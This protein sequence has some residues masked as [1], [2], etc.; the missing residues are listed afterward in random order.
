MDQEHVNFVQQYGRPPLPPQPPKKRRGVF[1]FLALTAIL[2]LGGFFGVKALISLSPSE[3]PYEYDPVTLEPKEPEGL[4]K[5]I[6]HFV[7]SKDIVLEGEKEDRI[8]ILLLGMGGPGHDGPYL[9]D[10]IIIASVKPSTG[11]VAMISI[12]RDLGVDIP[13]SG[14]RKINSANAIGENKRK[15]WGAAFATEL[16]EETFDIDIHYYVRVDFQAFEDIVNEVGGVSVNVD[17]SFTDYEYPA[18]YD[19]YQ[20]VSFQQ[21]IRKMNGETALTYARSRHGNNGEGSDFARAKRQQKVLLA[22]KEKILSARTLANPVKI[23]NIIESLD[24]HVTTNMEF[25]DIIEFLKTGRSVNSNKI[26]TVVLDNSPDGYL[27]NAYS[28]S[29]SFIMRPKGGDFEPIK[30]LIAHVF[31]QEEATTNNTPTQDKT[32]VPLGDVHIEILNGTWRAGLAARVQKQL[33]DEGFVVKT[34]GNTTERPVMESSV[35]TIQKNIDSG[36]LGGIKETLRIP[37]KQG[38]GQ[39]THT[40]TTD[41]LVILGEDFIE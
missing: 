41:V 16:I 3:D 11:E 18:P 20:V 8:N 4:F 14:W 9:T 26:I 27:E 10:T 30:Q 32:S 5:R 1:L 36:V 21:G 2:L 34:L 31:E 12:P 7:F 17:R 35:Y 40:S 13:G 22:L 25:P 6:K 38:S 19:Q 23:H 15:H 28:P 29:G 33:E 39:F 37:L 24:S